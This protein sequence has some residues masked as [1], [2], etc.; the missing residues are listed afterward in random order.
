MGFFSNLKDKFS[1]I[2]GGGK[3]SNK[4]TVELQYDKAM[5]LFENA[6]GNEAIEILEGIADIGINEQMYKQFGLDA[7]KVLSE[8]YEKG[9]YSNTKTEKDLNK[10]ASYLEKYTN[11][12][13]DSEMI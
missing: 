5:S 8:F 10:A 1:A 4:S 7:L 9:E 2:T 6:N 3:K 12:S 11:L 13:N